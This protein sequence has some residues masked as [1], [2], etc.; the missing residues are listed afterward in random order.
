MQ[1]EAVAAN[2]DLGKDLEH[3]EVLT[4]MYCTYMC[5]YSYVC[6]HF[7]SKRIENLEEIA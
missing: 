6:I 4:H 5:L 7:Q 2:E 1:R 3:V